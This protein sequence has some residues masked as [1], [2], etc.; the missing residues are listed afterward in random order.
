MFEEDDPVGQFHA[1][2]TAGCETCHADGGPGAAY[3]TVTDV[4][5]GALTERSGVIWDGLDT[6][7]T[8]GA[9]I[10]WTITG[11]ADDGTDL[12]ITWQAD[13]DGVGVDPCNDTAGPGAPVF[14]AD[15]EGNLSILRNYAQGEDFILATR[16]TVASVSSTGTTVS[17]T[18]PE[19]DVLSVVTPGV[20]PG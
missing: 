9:K 12:T 11:V 19:Q 7:V 14:F 20:G 2:I 16:P 8:E 3:Q 5:N 10:D 1:G 13:Y 4:H 17:A 18:L 15:G 6:S